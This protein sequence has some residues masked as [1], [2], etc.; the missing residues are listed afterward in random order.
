MLYSVEFLKEAVEE[1]SNIDPIWQKR[2]LNKIKIL[3][4]DP[5]N[6]ANNIKKLK[7]KYQEYYR[8]RVGDYRVIY[9]QENDRLII[10]IIRIGHRKEIY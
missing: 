5:K 3:S 1:L 7:G 2:I 9:S 8:L 4:A 10:L 6:L